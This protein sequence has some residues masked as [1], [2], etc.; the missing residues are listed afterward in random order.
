MEKRKQEQL[1]NRVTDL[2]KR[3]GADLV[4]IATVETLSGGPPSADLTYV[5]PEAKSA[6]VFAISLDQDVIEPFIGKKDFKKFNINNVRTNTLA[7][8]ISM[9]L[10]KYIE[11]KGF[12]AVPLNANI[13]YRTD[14]KGGVFDEIPPI[15]HRYLAVRSGVGFFGF[16][17]NLLTREFGAAVILG[18]LVTEAELIPTDPVESKENYCNNCK[19]C[20]AACASEY[21]DP[22]ESVSVSLGDVEFTY[23]KRRHHWRCDYVCGGFAGLHKSKKWS[24]WS[25][26]RF[27]IPEKDEDFA[28]AF[29]KAAPSFKK[30]PK[31]DVGFY[32]FLMP[33]NVVELTCCFCQLVCNP[34]ED[35]R[36]KRLKLIRNSGVSIQKSDGSLCSVSAEEAEAWLSSLDEETRSLYM[37]ID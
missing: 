10:A 13:D 25:P 2:A 19:I 15:S 14:T 18:S 30:R 27:E 3:L 7:S 5:L 37:E 32:H 34:D 12:K 22:R 6:I 31:S 8:G 4:G 28:E 33:G 24:T 9:D 1:T 11:M 16:S 26:A 29:I 23:A 21:M 20:V 36:K 17:G 35:V